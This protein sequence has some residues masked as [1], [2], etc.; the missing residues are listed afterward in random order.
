M[1]NRQ[2]Q[3]QEDTHFRVLRLLHAQPQLSQRQLA[4][5]LGI[6]L[7]AV[8]YCLKALIAKGQIKAQNFT[9]SASKLHYAY[10]LTPAGVREKAALTGRFLQRKLREYEALQAEID[11]LRHE[12]AQV[13]APAQSPE[14][15]PPPA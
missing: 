7:G 9:N 15:G 4:N 11:T 14:P 3:L 12:A 8:H 13:Q 5:E 2:A 10:L 6:S 1:P